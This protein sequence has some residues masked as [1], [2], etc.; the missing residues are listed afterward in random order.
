MVTAREVQDLIETRPDLE[1]VLQAVLAADTP[2]AFDDVDVDSGRFGELVSTDLVEPAS[3]GGYRLVD[4]A[5]TRAALAGAVDSTASSAV[6]TPEDRSLTPPLQANSL[7]RYGLLALAVGVVVAFRLV[8]VPTVFRDDEIV[9]MA[10]D[11]YF[12]RFLVEQTLA[13]PE[14]SLSSF[15]TVVSRGEPLLIATLALVATGAGGSQASV[16]LVLAWYPVVVTALTAVLVYAVAN[17]LTDDRRVALA[18]VLFLAVLPGHAV[19]TSLGFADHHAFDYLWVTLTMFGLVAVYRASSPVTRQPTVSN[20]VPVVAV[21]LGVAGSILAWEAGPL[22]IIPVG[23][24]VAADALRAVDREMSSLQYCAP[25]TLGV[26]LGAGLVWA[27]HLALGWHTTL[28]AA[29]PLGLALGC[30]GL[31]LLGEG[32]HRFDRSATT[33]AAVEGGLALA[34]L[35]LF[36]FVA[37]ERWWTRITGSI[38]GRLLARRD[39]QEVTSLLTN[40]DQW[41]LLF[42]LLLLF[43]L[44][45]MAY[46][47]YRARTDGRWLPAAV[48]GWY[49]LLLAAIQARFVGQFSLVLAVFAGF[50]FVHVAGWVDLVRPPGVL[51]DT[52]IASLRRP[53]SKQT[54]ALSV[55]FLLLASLSLV[56]TPI[57]IGQNTVSDGQYE[58]ATAMADYSDDHGLSYS[59]NYVL[60]RWDRNRMYNYHVNGQSRSY[61]YARNTY[62][63]F[64]RATDGRQW[65]QRLEGRAGFVVTS[66]FAVTADP[67]ALGTRLHTQYGTRTETAP[68]VAHYRLISV[69]DEGAYKAF[70]VVPGATITG[71]AA[72]NETVTVNQQITVDGVT[73]EYE[74]RTTTNASGR[75]QT[76]VASPGFYTV[77]NQ[78]V[79]VPETAVTNGSTVAA[80]AT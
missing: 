49:F 35:V 57:V 26:G 56:L 27:V 20:V 40:P 52:P 18:A 60:S 68:A 45:Y 33:L 65:Y 80:S 36:R 37:P 72:P 8:S 16:G 1:P 31:V 14:L 28:V 77:G 67:R 38:T 5:A 9:L 10:N 71:T 2:W 42:G 50:G 55:L 53:D 24:L 76:R 13:A 59:D 12:Y 11:P 63:Q 3:D 17:A 19:R 61:G 51:T 58:T 73:F 69:A 54:A 4:P 32:W 74:R 62:D 6:D 15:P 21:G 39:I 70:A 43:A 29:A 47:A 46:G 78:T 48:Y 23:L 34:G 79:T 30:A 75:F 64:A 22:L 25:I 7:Q 66:D 41:F 44:P